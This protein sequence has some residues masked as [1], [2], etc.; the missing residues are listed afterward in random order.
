MS[1]GIRFLYVGDA[2]EGAR[3]LSDMRSVAPVILDDVAL[4]PYSAV[5]SVH[6]DPVDPMPAFDAGMLLSE[7]SDETVRRLL[8]VAGP[9]SASP[10]VMLE[11]RQLGGAYAR[12]G[13]HPSAF[14][15]RAAKFSVL[16][17]GV[18]MDPRVRPHAD[19]LFT[20]LAEWDFGGIWPNFAP[21][22]D[23]AIGSACLLRRNPRAA[24]RGV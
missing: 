16:V 21:P 8:E 3:L 24:G 10:Q 4:K 5:D 14:D 17:V 20:A 9:G 7:L 1:I 6:A 15:H 11:V 22:H 19:E 12:P 23:K 18:A 13:Q 2:T